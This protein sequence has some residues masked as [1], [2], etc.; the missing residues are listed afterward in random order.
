MMSQEE[1]RDLYIGITEAP[2]FFFLTPRR[3]GGTFTLRM[4]VKLLVQISVPDD[5]MAC[6]LDK[7]KDWPLRVQN[8][9][10]P[11]ITCT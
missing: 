8:S 7:Q 5:K 3:T 2:V 11:C 1:A 4:E 6:V 9:L 10:G